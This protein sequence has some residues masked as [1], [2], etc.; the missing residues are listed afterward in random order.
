M[1]IPRGVS[2]RL[3]NTS[4]LEK[5]SADSGRLQ[6]KSADGLHLYLHLLN[7]TFFLYFIGT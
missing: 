5:T 4:A 6:Q 7:L 2:R 3:K 1:S